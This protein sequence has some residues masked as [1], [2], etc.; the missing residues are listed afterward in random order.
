MNSASTIGTVDWTPRTGGRLEPEEWHR[1]VAVLALV[2]VRDIVGRVSMLA[3]LDQGRRSHVPPER[4]L[5]PN[6]PL[7][8]AARDAAARI[9]PVPCSPTF[10]GRTCSAG[11][12]VSSNRATPWATSAS[13]SHSRNR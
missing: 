8:R 1:L 4:L 13:S 5:P 3:H 10:T 2:H 12:W 7:T 6:S 9:R 11:R